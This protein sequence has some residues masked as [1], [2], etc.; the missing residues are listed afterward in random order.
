MTPKKELIQ[1]LMESG[2]HKE[3]DRRVSAAFLLMNEAKT[4]W[5]EAEEFA[6]PYGLIV[7]NGKRN[8]SRLN[9]YYEAFA[10]ELRT[11]INHGS[12]EAK[13]HFWEDFEELDNMVHNFLNMKEESERTNDSSKK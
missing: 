6:R 9:I 5:D 8:L 1:K 2:T 12:K 7:G 13:Q 11:I 10:S 4:L 3:I